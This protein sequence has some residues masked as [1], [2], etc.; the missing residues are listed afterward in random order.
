[1]FFLCYHD[2][3]RQERWQISLAFL[4]DSKLLKLRV[5][6]SRTLME[7]REVGTSGLE[8]LFP[9][10][11]ETRRKAIRAGTMSTAN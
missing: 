11:V 6:C 2:S 7:I 3:T 10:K 5:L 4:A 1:L 9:V 8:F